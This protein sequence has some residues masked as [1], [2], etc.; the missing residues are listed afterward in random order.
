MLIAA[1]TALKNSLRSSDVVARVGGDEF[2]VI[3]PDADENA[4]QTA[5]NRI[6]S[7]VERFNQDNPDMPL[8][9]SLGWATAYCSDNMLD[10]YKR[11]DDNMYRKK[12]RKKNL[13]CS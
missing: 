1:A 2:V 8:S 10:L 9:I 3:L 4:A 12:A 6:N 13:P 5:Y 7:T 11:A